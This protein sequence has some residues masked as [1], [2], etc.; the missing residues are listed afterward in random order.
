MFRRQYLS[1]F[2]LLI[3]SIFLWGCPK[4]VEV[5]PP[6][7]PSWVNPMVQLLDA[8]SSVESFQAKASIRIDTVREGEEMNFLLNGFLIYQRPDKLRLLGYHPLGMG[9]FDALLRNG[10]FFLLIPPQKRAY[11]GEISQFEEVIEKAGP[12]EI[13]TE[14]DEYSEVPNRIRIVIVEKETSVEVR[15]KNISINPDLPGDSFLWEVPEGV[16]V[17]S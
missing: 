7:K 8:L 5:P 1:I 17:R 2:F 3:L 13:S 10:E 9:L 15:L 11:T 12:I 16:E 6:E 4:R 14:R